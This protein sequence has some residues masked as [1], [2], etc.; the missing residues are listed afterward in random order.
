ME[1]NWLWKRNRVIS[2]VHFRRS[3][4]TERL[5]QLNTLKFEK[6]VFEPGMLFSS[7]T[8]W[9][10]DKGARG[11][12]H[13]G[14]DL[15]SYKACDGTLRTLEEGTR[16][17]IIFDGRIV[18]AIRDFIGYSV[19]AAHE[20][21]DRDSGLF[22]IYG[23]VVQAPRVRIDETLR[24]GTEIAAMAGSSAGKAP[25]HLHISVAMIPRYRSFEALNWKVLE[26][27]KAVRFFDPLDII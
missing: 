10:G 20:I 21:Y 19:F 11:R 1:G 18:G 12:R 6:W 3:L 26:E 27:D 14:L 13:N 23:H 25:C 4:F 22:T 2:N 16:I 8:K 15:R 17:P 9:W 24:E 7:G 5:I